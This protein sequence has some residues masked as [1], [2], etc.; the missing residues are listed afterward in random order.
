MIHYYGWN[1]TECKEILWNGPALYIPKRY[2]SASRHGV[3][4][5]SDSEEGIKRMIDVKNYQMMQW[6]KNGWG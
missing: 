6:R 5:N 1:Y 2:W 3:T 4:M